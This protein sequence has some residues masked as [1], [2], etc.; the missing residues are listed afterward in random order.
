VED[1]RERVNMIWGIR[2]RAA[3]SLSSVWTTPMYCI[4]ISLSPKN[5]QLLCG[6][7]HTPGPM[8]ARFPPGSHARRFNYGFSQNMSPF[9][10]VGHSLE[11]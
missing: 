9:L 7:H 2:R 8:V 3:L 11:V 4:R 10:K 6:A 5:P 1:R